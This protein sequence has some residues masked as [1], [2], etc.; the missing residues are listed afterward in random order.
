MNLNK[1]THKS[2]EAVQQ[3]FVIAEQNQHPSVTNIHLLHALIDQ[4]QSI[5]TSLL[6][7]LSIDVNQTLQKIQQEYQKL[8]NISG[9]GNTAQPNPEYR[10]TLFQAEKEC[11]QLDDQFI[12]SEHLLLALIRTKSIKQIINLKAQQILDKLSELRGTQKVTDQDPESKYQVIE[13]YTRDLTQFAREGKI[14]PVIGRDEEIRRI[15]QIL[16]RRTKNNPCLVGEPGTGKTAIAEGLARKIVEGDVPETI[17]NKKLLAMDLGAMIAGAKF[18]GEFEERLK[19]LIQEVEASAG[20]IILFIDE[21]HTIV[22]AGATDGAMDAGN[23]LKP[24]L[25]RGQLRTIGA[26]TVK[27]YRKYIEKDAA[28]ERR[29]QPVN[30][31]EPSVKDSVSILRGIKDKY[32]V[33]HGVRIRDNAVIASVNLSDRYIGDRFLPDKAIDLMDEAASVLRIE[34]DSKPTI[35]DRLERQIR[36][37]EIER[38]ALKNEPDDN[39]AIRLNELEKDLANKKEE[40]DQLSIHWSNEKSVID[41][42]KALGKQIG[43]LKIEAEQ[44]ERNY[45]LQRVAEINYGEIPKL[46]ELISAKKVNLQEIQKKNQILK[47]EVTEEDIAEVVSRW[48]GIPVSRMLEEEMNKLVRMEDELAKRVIGQDKAIKAISNAVRRS[49]AGLSEEGK[50]IGSFIFMGPT[51]VG[52][53]ELAKTLAD[54]MFNDEKLI[55]RIDMSEYM[56][57][58]SV[59]KLIGAPP[60]YVGYDEGGQLTE[61]VR[62]HPYSVVLFDEIEKAHPDVFN[63]LL[64]V[65]DDGRLTDSKGKVVDFKNTIIIMTS[66]LASQEIFD[67]KDDIESQKTR[68]HQVLKQAF[69]PEFLNRIDETVIFQ[70]LMMNQLNEI[71]KIQLKDLEKRLQNNQMQIQ[72]TESAIEY[73]ASKGFSPEFGARPLKRLIQNTIMDELSL[74]IIEGKIQKHQTIH[75]DCKDNEFIFKCD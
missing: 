4:E 53:T 35:I 41:E 67:N 7:K 29:F 30:V 63:V 31:N 66:N 39:S 49:R 54:F 37:M 68:V 6:N 58:H 33:H 57:K 24:A 45:N 44:Q 62:R 5:V 10:N 25:A 23:L 16:S 43:Q 18:R 51:G 42:I 69:R 9:S 11:T 59:A 71:V 38:M 36:Q 28:L 34:I 14:D 2:Q 70:H 74:Q 65:L 60:G 3:S 19:A 32:E 72:F 15:M 27:E 75:A 46:E 40:F 12:S 64:Q 55:T 52:K 50:P 22:G 73:L 17:K 48:T 26:T 1:F 8:P 56:E 47:E 20:D 21:L 13:K 61:S